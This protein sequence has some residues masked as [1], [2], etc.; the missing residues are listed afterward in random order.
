VIPPVIAGANSSGA[1]AT[2]L[3][4]PAGKPKRR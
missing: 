2:P 3:I 4:A 1:Y